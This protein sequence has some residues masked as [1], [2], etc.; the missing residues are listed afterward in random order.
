MTK[1]EIKEANRLFWMVKGHLIPMSW[2]E[3]DVNAIYESYF[4]RL[5][6]NHEVGIREAGFEAA[7]KER[8]AQI[9]NE[10]IKTIAILGGHYD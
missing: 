3:K 5:W 6:G 10:E 4:R 9:Y 2:S 7:Y 8:E 1:W